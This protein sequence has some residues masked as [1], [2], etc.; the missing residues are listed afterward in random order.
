MRGFF[1]NDLRAR[2]RV[3]ASGPSKTMVLTFEIDTGASKELL[4]HRSLADE[5][6]LKTSTENEFATLADGTT[7]VEVASAK[8]DIVWMNETKPIDVLVWP[9]TPGTA[10]PV[11]NKNTIDGL[12]GRGLLADTKLEIDYVN[13][14]IVLTQPVVDDV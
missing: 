14:K 3:Q 4:I 5:L 8:L 11:R 10:A 6:G 1:T 2:L 7:E 12:I 13:R 9:L